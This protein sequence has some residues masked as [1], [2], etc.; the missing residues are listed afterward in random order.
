MNRLLVFLLLAAAIGAGSAGAAND[1][2]VLTDLENPGYH[3]QP[4]WFKPSFLDIRED[5]AE[6]AEAGKRVMLYFYQDGCPYCSKLLREG[7]GDREISRTAREGFDVIAINIWGDREVTG[8]DGASTTEK[9]FAAALGVQYTPTIL[10]LDEDA[11]TVLRID[12]YYPPHQLHAGLR[13]VAQ[14]REQAGESFRDFA[15]RQADRAAT[16]KLHQES[17]FLATPLRLADNRAQATRPLLVLFEQPVCA[18][19]DELHQDILRR[20]AVAL[21]LT[22]LDVA[23]VD[24]FGDDPVQTPGGPTLPAGD[25][26]AGLG[27]DYTPSLVFFDTAGREVFRAEGY[28]KAFH[29]HG[30]LDY[31]ATGAYR[32]QPSFQRWLQARTDALHARGIGYELMR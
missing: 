8:P 1:S 2:D 28:L 9:R 13:Y 27:I 11:A 6:A 10:L 30:L 21:A 23:V 7:F 15:G 31:V 17:G 26:A 29:V 25:W 16:G 22:N 24:A 14:R 5:V 20:D 32:H 3:A 19:C 18:A 12:G 4:D